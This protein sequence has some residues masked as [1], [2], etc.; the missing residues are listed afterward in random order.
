LQLIRLC[1]QKTVVD[2]ASYPVVIF[3]D[4]EIQYKSINGNYKYIG[5]YLP[6]SIKVAEAK[7]KQAKTK[8]IFI[9]TKNVANSRRV[10]IS[11]SGCWYFIYI[12]LD[13]F[14]QYGKYEE[15]SV[16]MLY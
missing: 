10:C 4:S 1:G 3:N 2:Y 11:H 9:F 14:V 8:K 16:K 12:L 13:V 15:P 6:F 7:A 5:S